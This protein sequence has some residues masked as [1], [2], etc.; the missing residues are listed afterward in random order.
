MNPSR[1]EWTEET[2]NPI[3][4]C[5]NGCPWCYAR[6]IAETR[7]RGQ[8]GYDQDKPF[9]LTFHEKRLEQPIRKKTP[10]VIFTPSMG[11]MFCEGVPDEWI[12]KVKDVIE[13]CSHHRFL[14]LSKSV[15]RAVSWRDKFPENCWFGT[16]IVGYRDIDRLT[17]FSLAHHKIKS[18]INDR[19]FL[20]WEP[21]IDPLPV[22]YLGGISWVVMGAMSG[23][24]K[25]RPDRRWI[26]K[27]AEQCRAY[28]KDVLM[29]NSLIEIVGENHMVREFPGDIAKI[30][31][32]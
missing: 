25:F 2:W 9:Q 29:K 30:M 13:Q 32:A 7:L 5:T 8:H 1:I 4:G 15:T 18:S 14:I 19:T 6:R 22:H 20:S 16:S 24:N 28:G 3:T 21:I 27:A 12:M 26:L 23:P 11:D 31:E 17:A 10:T